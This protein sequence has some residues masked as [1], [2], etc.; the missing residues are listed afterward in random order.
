LPHWKNSSL[1]DFLRRSSLTWLHVMRE[2]EE[3]RDEAKQEK[4]PKHD[5][6]ALYQHA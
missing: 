3:D 4:P 1:W 5:D 2:H 6:K